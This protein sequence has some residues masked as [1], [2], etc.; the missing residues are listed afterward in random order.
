MK[1]LMSLVLLFSVITVQAAPKVMVSILPQKFLVQRLAGDALE[2]TVMVGPG[3]SPATYEP[4]PR[5]MA[6]LEQAALYYRIGVPF[7][8]VWMGRIQA[9]NPDLPVLDARNGIELRYIDG[10]HHEAAHDHGAEPRDPHIWLSPPL[11]RTMA[12]KLA[13]RLEALWP[14]QAARFDENLRTLD[15]DL[16]ALDR[17]IRATLNTSGVDRF[18]VFH[19]SWGYFADA[20]GLAQIPIER[21]GKE[22]GARALAELIDQARAQ[23]IQVIFVQPQFSQHQAQAL[24]RATNARVA[25]LDPLSE[26]YLTNMRAV[27]RAIA[28]SAE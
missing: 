17:E 11:M 3:E 22:P 23:A 28:G 14:E 5:R 12:A 13:Q 16:L 7:E 26:D 20:Y 24:A 27:A 2:V 21:E 10:H 25:A 1:A 6:E 18:M 15:A 9:E 19:P 4:G 8:Q